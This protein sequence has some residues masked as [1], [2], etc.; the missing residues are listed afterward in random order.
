MKQV[1]TCC[2]VSWHFAV[3]RNTKTLQKWFHNVINHFAMQQMSIDRW[4]KFELVAL[5]ID[6]LL[7]YEI[8]RLYQNYF[9]I[10]LIISQCN[11]CQL[12]DETS[13]NLLFCQLTRNTKTLPKG[14]HNVIN[15]FVMQQMPIDSWNKFELVVLSSDTLLYYQDFIKV[16]S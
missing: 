6:T 9:I 12:T 8:S 1:W 15:H 5:S 11:K 4:N 13:L 3:L 10:L 7:H 16:I 14:F 2:F